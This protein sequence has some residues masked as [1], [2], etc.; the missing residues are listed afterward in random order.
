MRGLLVEFALSEVRSQGLDRRHARVSD[1]APSDLF[2]GPL[3]YTALFGNGCPAA[4]SGLETLDYVLVNG[5]HM[6][7]DTRPNL[8]SAQPGRGPDGELICIS[9][10]RRSKKDRPPAFIQQVLSENVRALRDRKYPDVA[11]ETAANKLLAKASDTSL[12]QIQRI[13]ALEVAAGI[14]VVERLAI[15]LGV[16]PQDMLEP[17][18]AAQPD[19]PLETRPPRPRP[20]RGGKG[21]TARSR[22]GT[23]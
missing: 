7:A 6:P 2:K 14:D 16:R 18:F 21:L 15:A 13:I 4:F 23:Y 12:S 17:Y 20:S 11:H 10:G 1:F 3:G 5:F 19:K 9:V 22:Q 8:G